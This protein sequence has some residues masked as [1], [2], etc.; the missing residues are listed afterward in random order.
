MA[1]SSRIVD[2]NFAW[3]IF[4]VIGLWHHGRRLQTCNEL[5]K[6]IAHLGLCGVALIARH[7]VCGVPCCPPAR[8]FQRQAHIARNC[9]HAP[10]A[11]FGPRA[12]WR[13]SAMAS[14]LSEVRGAR[15]RDRRRSWLLLA[16]VFTAVDDGE[17]AGRCAASAG[18]WSRG[19]WVAGDGLVVCRECGARLCRRHS[20]SSTVQRVVS[21]SLQLRGGGRVPAS[22]KRMRQK[23][24]REQVRAPGS[25]AAL[26]PARAPVRRQRNGTIICAC[27]PLHSHAC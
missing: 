22:M 17:G 11:G 16:A 13:T 18:T 5:R 14:T 20:Q 10:V 24:A 4:I 26:Q 9:V 15:G 6:Q 23:E 19:M 8:E 27:A 25:V 21:A 12:T 3:A 7:R 2:S 1:R